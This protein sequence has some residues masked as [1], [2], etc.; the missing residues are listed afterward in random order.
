M[1]VFLFC[2]VA[3]SNDNIHW[4]SAVQAFTYY[5]EQP[6]VVVKGDL[7]ELLL[8]LFAMYCERDDDAPPAYEMGLPA[9]AGHNAGPFC[10][11]ILTVTQVR[12]VQSMCI[13][14]KKLTASSR[15]YEVQTKGVE[16]ILLTFS[17]K[18]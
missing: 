12:Q 10:S 5:D 7:L 9:M 14:H 3:A 18:F 8:A 15:S 16:F 6:P 13:S 17:R 1:V 4:S 2:Q 11:R